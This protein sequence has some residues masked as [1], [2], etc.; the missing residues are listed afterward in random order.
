MQMPDFL[1]KKR[2]H[3]DTFAKTDSGAMISLGV[4]LGQEIDR[5][6][7]M[8]KVIKKSLSELQKAIKG[9]VV[10]SLELEHMFDGF[11]I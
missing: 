3:P 4:F 10:M 9:T 6:N 2:A 5:F 1:E 8:L 7:K 11:L